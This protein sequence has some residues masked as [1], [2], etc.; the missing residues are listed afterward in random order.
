MDV[1]QPSLEWSLLLENYLGP[2][3]TGLVDAYF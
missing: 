1:H 2:P 3:V